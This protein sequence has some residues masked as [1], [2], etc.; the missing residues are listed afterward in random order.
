[1][2]K[3]YDYKCPKCGKVEEYFVTERG[4]DPLCEECSVVMVRI[5]SAPAFKVNGYSYANGYNT[6][7]ERK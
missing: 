1:M 5:P 6:P 7:G 4:K 2:M 3:C